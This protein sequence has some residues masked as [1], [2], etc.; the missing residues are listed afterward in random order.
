MDTEQLQEMATVNQELTQQLTKRN[1]QYL[2]DLKKALQNANLSEEAQVSA[3]HDL[4]VP[5]VAEQKSGKTARQLFGTVS[6]CAEKI[7]HKPK[8]IPEPSGFLM[9]LDNAMLL[10]GILTVTMYLMELFS[11]GKSQAMGLLTLL[12]SAMAGGLMFYF[13][14]KYVTRYDRPNADK[15]KRPGFLKTGLILV[16]SA[17]LWIVVFAGSTLF[18][19]AMLNPVVDPIIAVA[20]GGVTLLVR[21]FLKKKFNMQNSFA[22]Y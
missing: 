4:L 13:M 17:L 7:I 8:E 15:S 9:W 19:P 12:L 22:N 10:F 18:L 1:E 3:L 14:Y 6:E 21:Y 5:L 16:S 20:L 2:F 11:K